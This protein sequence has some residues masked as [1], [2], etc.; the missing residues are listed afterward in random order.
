[1]SKIIIG[2]DPD[3]DKSGVSIYREN[4]SLELD[5][6]TFPEVLNLFDHQLEN[7]EKVVIEA[8]WLV[9]KSN[10]HARAGMTPQARER[11]AK[12]VGENHAVGKLLE[13]CAKAKGLE[14]QLLTPQGKCN[15]AQFK[16]FTGYQGST[17]QETRDAGM[18]VF[19]MPFKNK[20]VAG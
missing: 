18:L 3:L 8:G 6:L 1:M 2:I 5:C 20:I 9:E 17:N 16:R 14:V 4:K 13:C 12:N 11:Q 19:G 7:I 10:W 15:A